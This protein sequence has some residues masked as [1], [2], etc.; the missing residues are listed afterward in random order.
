MLKTAFSFV[1]VLALVSTAVAADKLAIGDKAPDFSA[2]TTA[3]K[4]IALGDYKDAKVVVVN[5][6]CNICPV[7]VAYEDRFIEFAK[8]YQDK[9]VAFVAINV[10]TTEDLEAMKQRAEEKGFNFPYAYDASGDSCRAYGA[11]VTPHLFVL[12]KDR[13][14]AYVG[15]FD[16]SMKKPTKTYVKDAVDALLSGKKVDVTTTKAVG[17]GIRPAK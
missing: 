7:A 16:D 11:Q 15:A 17:C 2:T 6:T 13:T 10:N 3:G 12:D 1:A 9:G 4:E 8:E 14:L 5:F